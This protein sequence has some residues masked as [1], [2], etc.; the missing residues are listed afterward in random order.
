[1]SSQPHKGK[2]AA[3]LPGANFAEVVHVPEGI[4][5]TEDAQA[6]ARVHGIPAEEIAQGTE[7]C[8]NNV[9]HESDDDQSEDDLPLYPRPPTCPPGLIRAAHN[10]VRFDFVVLLFECHRHGLRTTPF[11]H[12][13]CVDTLHVLDNAKNELGGACFKL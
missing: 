6:A 9:I 5:R 12:W 2:E 7:A 1:M 13:F 3:H 4:W 10:G 11:R 8:L